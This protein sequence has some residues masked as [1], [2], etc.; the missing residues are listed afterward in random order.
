[1][2]LSPQRTPT[3]QPCPTSGWVEEVNDSGSAVAPPGYHLLGEVARALRLGEAP[4]LAGRNFTT[5]LSPQLHNSTKLWKLYQDCFHAVFTQDQEDATDFGTW[6]I[7]CAVGSC[8]YAASQGG[9]TK[10]LLNFVHKH[11]HF[12]HPELLRGSQ[13]LAAIANGQL[14]DQ[15]ALRTAASV[16]GK[17]RKT[18][19][20]FSHL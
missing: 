15:N 2:S 4:A 19:Q 16:D 13:F 12:V 7:R 1:M 14:Q 17:K 10:T 18:C 5:L 20:V 3:F 8:S 9:S 6:N 11:L